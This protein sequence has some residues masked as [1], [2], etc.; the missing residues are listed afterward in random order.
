MAGRLECG[1]TRVLAYEADGV[2]L[3]FRG[4][5]G[6]SAPFACEPRDIAAGDSITPEGEWLIAAFDT[7]GKHLP[8][9]VALNGQVYVG[10]MLADSL[11]PC[12]P[13]GT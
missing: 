4:I 7:D 12:V 2:R 11:C 10:P 3:E 1:S 13:R 5:G 6:V 9:A 8:L